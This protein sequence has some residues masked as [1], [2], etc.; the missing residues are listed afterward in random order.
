MQSAQTARRAQGNRW[1]LQRGAGVKDITPDESA[2]RRASETLLVQQ[3][4]PVV[5]IMVADDLDQH[6]AERSWVRASRRPSSFGRSSL[7]TRAFCQLL[8]ALTG[9][10]LW[11]SI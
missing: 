8:A 3:V 4:R 2:D 1:R 7:A 9:R 5:Q 6:R 10:N 11:K